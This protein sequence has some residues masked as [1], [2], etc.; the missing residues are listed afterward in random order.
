[1][2]AP[3]AANTPS[4]IPIFDT[5]TAY[6]RANAL[7]AAIE[8]EVFTAIGEGNETSEA[9]ARRCSASPRGM[10]ILCDYL[11]TNGFLRK[12]GNRYKLTP[13]S[14]L[15]LDKRSPAYIGSVTVFLN[16]PLLAD[17]FSSLTEAVRKGGTASKTQGTI[18][19]DNPVWVEFARGMAPMMA[20]PADRIADVLNIRDAGKCK[21]LD[22]AAGHGMFGITL[23]R[24][25]PAA[26]VHAVDSPNVLAL[27]KENAH[28][29]GVGARHHLLPGSAFD[30]HFGEGYDVVLLTNFLHHFDVTTCESLLRKCH[31]ALKPGG[32]VATLE[33]VPNDDRV[34]PSHSAG[35]S[36]VMLASTP[37]GDA[38]TFCE[39]ETMFKNTGFARNEIHELPPTPQ[40]LVIS[41]KS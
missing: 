40:H 21:V 35:F 28:K 16:S 11:A 26:E 9:A 17:H 37:S 24:L 13:E 7:K 15:F 22:I 29:A 2:S 31:A 33:F 30:V 14:A 27:A 41:H 18:A 36:L 12:E 1:M 25:N 8:L 4:P 23:A 20:M 32:R 10:R 5:L 38:Y 6:Q 3:A 19:P 39:L 34:T